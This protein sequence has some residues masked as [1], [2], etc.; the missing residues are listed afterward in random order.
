MS[1]GMLLDMTPAAKP[2]DQKGPGIVGMV[3]IRASR[4]GAKRT[5]GGRDDGSR[6]NEDID[7]G[8]AIPAGAVSRIGFTPLAAHVAT[9]CSSSVPAGGCRFAG[10]APALTGKDI[11]ATTT[12]A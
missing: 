9:L 8:V 11:I 12:G 5:A 7:P 10:T 4:L 6:S 3:S 1:T 2:L